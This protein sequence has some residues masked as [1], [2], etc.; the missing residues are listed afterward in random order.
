MSDLTDVRSEIEHARKNVARMRRDLLAL[1]K[2]GRSTK[3][4]E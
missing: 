1:Q 3:M 2:A 4:T